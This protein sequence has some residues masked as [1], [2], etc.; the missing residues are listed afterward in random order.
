MESQTISKEDVTEVFYQIDKGEYIQFD[1]TL[2][3]QILFGDA[4][5]LVSIAD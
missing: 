5:S 2:Q 4:I 1:M 3:M